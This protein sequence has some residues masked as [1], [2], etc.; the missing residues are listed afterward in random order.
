MRPARAVNDRIITGPA[1]PG[2]LLHALLPVTAAIAALTV[3]P[4]VGWQ[5]AV[6]AFAVLGM[7][8]PQ[9]LGGWLSIACIAVGMLIAEPDVWR[10]M[11]SV[12]LVHVVHVLSALLPIVPWRGRV[13]LAALRPTLIRLLLIQA[14]AQPVVLAVMLVHVAGTVTLGSAV[15]VGAA[16]VAGLAILFLRGIRRRQPGV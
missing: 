6:V 11:I 7:L 3:V 4:V 10:T 1:V 15:L 14:V 9:T 5:I 2:A 12:L 16:A 13:V 8:F